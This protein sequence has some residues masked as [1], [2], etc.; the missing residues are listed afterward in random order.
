M[1]FFQTECVYHIHTYRYE[2]M[3]ENDLF[4]YRYTTFLNVLDEPMHAS[5]N[6]VYRFKHLDVSGHIYIYEESWRTAVRVKNE[7]IRCYTELAYENEQNEEYGRGMDMTDD[8]FLRLNGANIELYHHEN[9]VFENE[10]VDMRKEI[11][12]FMLSISDIIDEE[13]RKANQYMQTTATD[14]RP[15]VVQFWNFVFH[16]IVNREDVEGDDD[17][18]DEDEEEEEEDDDETDADDEN[19]F[20]LPL[21]EVRRRLPEECRVIFYHFRNKPLIYGDVI[22]C[23]VSILNTRH[24]T[25]NTTIRDLYDFCFDIQE[26]KFWFYINN[27]LSSCTINSPDFKK[28]VDDDY[29]G[30]IRRKIESI[31]KLIQNDVMCSHPMQITV[32]R[33]FAKFSPL[34]SFDAW[35]STAEFLIRRNQ[36]HASLGVFIKQ[37][38]TVP[39]D[40]TREIGV[41]PTRS[42]SDDAT[43]RIVRMVNTYIDGFL[44]GVY[45]TD[46]IE[47]RFALD[48]LI[49]VLYY[50]VLILDHQGTLIPSTFVDTLVDISNRVIQARIM[51]RLTHPTYQYVGDPYQEQEYITIYLQKWTDAYRDDSSIEMEVVGDD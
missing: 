9:D 20:T 40:L 30:V 12:M 6:I 4:F 48:Y 47:S 28:V 14:E 2:T 23:L 10:A 21:R 8:Y 39:Q 45:R 42:I 11:F 26:D 34:F 46:N 22:E 19:D 41:S 44:T 15:M 36:M 38:M 24:I 17:D 7:I 3:Q 27:S 29:E 35:I 25:G 18:E 51:R 43:G 1:I 37:I 5:F 33:Y 31:R 49:N 32:E 16:Q 50:K 13:F